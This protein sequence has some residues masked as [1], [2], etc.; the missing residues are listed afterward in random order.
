MKAA[1]SCV[2]YG[3][4]MG[5]LF[6]TL[7]IVNL[8]VPE[9]CPLSIA[10]LIDDC[11]ENPPRERP[12][13]RQ[14]YDIIKA[15]LAPSQACPRAQ[16][17]RC[18]LTRTDRSAL[19]LDE[20]NVIPPEGEIGGWSDPLSVCSC[21]SDND[22]ASLCPLHG[23]MSR[24]KAS[25]GQQSDCLASIIWMEVVPCL[26]VPTKGLRGACMC[27][28]ARGGC[29]RGSSAALPGDAKQVRS[30]AEHAVAQE[31]WAAR[32]AHSYHGAV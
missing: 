30:A 23:N 18:R 19:D 29:P 9:E 13:A 2:F 3:C 24:Q 32:G 1:C 10:Q 8:Q 17:V 16:E 22:K 7:I 15:A 28:G 12:S 4:Q 11:L 21:L 14:A 20:S 5:N 25:C 27:A 31:P 26:Y 6:W